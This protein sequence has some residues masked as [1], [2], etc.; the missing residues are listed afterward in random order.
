MHNEFASPHT[1]CTGRVHVAAQLGFRFGSGHKGPLLLLYPKRNERRGRGSSR[2]K[3]APASAPP[4]DIRGQLHLFAQA[5]QCW[6]TRH[7]QA[8]QGGRGKCLRKSPVQ[9][10]S[11]TCTAWHQTVCGPGQCCTGEPVSGEAGI[12]TAT[13]IVC[14]HCPGFTPS[15]NEQQHDYC[16]T[17]VPFRTEGLP[18]SF[19]IFSDL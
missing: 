14:H 2:L 18:L 13:V 5:N 10:S 1:S 12:T 17:H 7:L 4:T 15:S 16:H 11:R 9:D 8:R 6:A 3:K 19:L